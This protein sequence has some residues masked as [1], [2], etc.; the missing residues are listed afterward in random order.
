MSELL[1]NAWNLIK[2]IPNIINNF[3]SGISGFLNF[4][5][6]DILIP[7]LSILGI[8]VIIFIYKFVR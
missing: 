1:N 4:M 2:F 8:I 3:I 6:D 7:L 5:P